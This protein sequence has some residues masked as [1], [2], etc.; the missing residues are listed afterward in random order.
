MQRL[1]SAGEKGLIDL[2]RLSQSLHHAARVFR[3][4]T[5]DRTT[6]RDPRPLLELLESSGDEVSRRLEEDRALY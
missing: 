1:T 4:F 5:L 2:P 6:P 3:V